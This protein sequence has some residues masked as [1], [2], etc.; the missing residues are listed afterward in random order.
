MIKASGI[1]DENT[2]L[3]LGGLLV[4]GGLCIAHNCLQEL[5]LIHTTLVPGLALELNGEPVYPDRPSITATAYKV[6]LRVRIEDSI[7]GPLALPEDIAGLSISGSIVDTGA[8]GL[9]AIGPVSGE[10]YGPCTTIERATILGAVSVRELALASESIC[11]GAVTLKK[12]QAGF[13]RFSY[14]PPDTF[15][16]QFRCQPE[17][18]LKEQGTDAES[19]NGTESNGE[20]NRIIHR[21]QVGFTSRRYGQPGYGQLAAGSPPEIRTGAENGSE[22]GAFNFLLPAQ[23][24][25]NL[26]LAL[27]D[28]LPFGLEAGIYY[29]T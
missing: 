7:V 22:M 20:R 6:A 15:P 13:A 19:G 23:R 18:A 5:R 10:M 11:E 4:E 26:R 25:A 17:L 8:A 29:V 9:L 27:D 16:K 3:T 21:L 12:R 28:Y 14:L 2:R 1:G 24:E